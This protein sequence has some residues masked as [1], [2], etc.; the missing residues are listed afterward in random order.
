M[1]GTTCAA[2]MAGVVV[3]AFVSSLAGQRVLAETV[4]PVTLQAGN[5]SSGIYYPERLLGERQL[6]LN[7]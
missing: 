2:L 4:E 3:S 1:S 5:I 6:V 7:P